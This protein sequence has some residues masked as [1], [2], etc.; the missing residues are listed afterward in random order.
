MNASDLVAALRDGAVVRERGRSYQARSHKGDWRCQVRYP[1]G[2]VVPTQG[3]TIGAALAL[4][5][6]TIV[7]REHLMAHYS[8]YVRLEF[9]D[10]SDPRWIVRRII[11]PEDHTILELA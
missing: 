7:V 3:S 10:N 9:E 6:F 8:D 1:F 11:E 4:A 5:D 2:A